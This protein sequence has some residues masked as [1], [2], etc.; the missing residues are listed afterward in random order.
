MASGKQ[1]L[2]GKLEEKKKTQVGVDATTWEW[3]LYMI[4][5]CAQRIQGAQRYRRNVP[6]AGTSKIRLCGAADTSLAAS[7][8]VIPLGISQTWELYLV[9]TQWV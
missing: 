4:S 7:E 8:T 6:V 9:L 3:L 1:L 2:P 5:L